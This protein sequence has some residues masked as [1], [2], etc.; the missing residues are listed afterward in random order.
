MKLNPELKDVFKE[1]NIDS[2]QGIFCLMSI[3]HKIPLTGMLASLL[4]STMMQI[5]VSKIVEKDYKTTPPSV[6]WNYPLYEGEETE[7]AWVDKEFRPLFKAANKL[8]AGSAS[9]CIRK[10]KDFFRKHPSVRKDDVLAAAKLYIS[11]VNDTTYLQQ[12][13]YFI[14]KNSDTKSA[15]TSRLEQYIELLKENRKRAAQG[16]I[17][18]PMGS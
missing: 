6:V 12:A 16:S 8:K 18:K 4:E 13:D 2:A 15:F 9:S 1:F 7:W 10:M 14:F 11:S 17:N 3:Y 5:N